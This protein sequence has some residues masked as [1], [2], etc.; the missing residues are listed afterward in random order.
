[1]HTLIVGKTE[2]GKT[3]FMT[4]YLLKEYSRI[5]N[6][7]RVILYDKDFHTSPRWRKGHS[8]PV[9]GFAD[10]EAFKEAVFS[11]VRCVVIVEECSDLSVADQELLRGV[12]AKGRHLGHN[13]HLL[14][15]R[16]KMIRPN[17]RSQ[18]T[19]LCCCALNPE[20]VKSVKEVAGVEEVEKAVKFKKGD[21]LFKLGS[22]ASLEQGRVF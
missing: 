3:T 6:A 12:A 9:E 1:M 10:V 14:A 20:D 19:A 17:L 22:F 21:A 11:N 8:M 16:P 7:K 4:E 13:V 18:T 5:G 2:S 15:Q